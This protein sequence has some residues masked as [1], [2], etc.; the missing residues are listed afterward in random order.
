V[1]IKLFLGASI[2]LVLGP[3]T[4]VAAPIAYDIDF[5]LIITGN[6]PTSGEFTYDAVTE[7][8]TDLTVVWEGV[9]FDSFMLLADGAPADNSP[10]GVGDAGSFALL[11][12][13]CPTVGRSDYLW[14][15]RD[16]VGPY[17]AFEFRVR[18]APISYSFLS[19]A[20]YPDLGSIIAQGDWVT[21]PVS[22]VPAPP[23]LLLFGTGLIGLIGFSKRRKAM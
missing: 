15:A 9:T 7:Q 1:K 14:S 2:L 4:G 8:L 5:N 18:Y 10:C 12:Q 13:T 23:A 3:L 22:P 17:S 20:P 19:F 21:T 11:T 16:Q 6:A